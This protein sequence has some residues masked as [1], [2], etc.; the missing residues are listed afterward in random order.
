MKKVLIGV[1]CVLIVVAIAVALV[2]NFG[3]KSTPENVKADS[4]TNN[5]ESQETKQE[6]QKEGYE[7]IV[8]K[9]EITLEKGK[10]TS[11]EI[12]FTNP[13][14]TSIREYIHCEDQSDIIV[15]RYTPLKDYKITVEVEALK[16]GTTEILV[17]DY[18]YPDV[19]EIVKVNVVEEN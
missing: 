8:S 15:V 16:A 10:E 11:F 18:D 17:C 2:M 12:T 19:K 14:E 13:D 4:N 6:E 3:A 7:I 1:L 5:V 9:K